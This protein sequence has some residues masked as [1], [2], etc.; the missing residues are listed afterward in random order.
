M[1]NRSSATAA[2]QVS[3]RATSCA[4]FCLQLFPISGVVT[5]LPFCIYNKLDR[6]NSQNAS[7][8][9]KGSSKSLWAV[10]SAGSNFRLCAVCEDH[11]SDWLILSL[12]YA[13]CL[14]PQLLYTSSASSRC[15]G[16]KQGFLPHHCMCMYYGSS[17]YQ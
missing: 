16:S 6:K 1:G 4:T 10:G 8:Y 9:K 17:T 13:E 2:L 14:T 5:Y 11:R 12:H 15:C 7:H 3:L